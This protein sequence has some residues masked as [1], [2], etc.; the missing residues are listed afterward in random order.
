MSRTLG[1]LKDTFTSLMKSAQKMGLEIIQEKTLYMYSGKDGNKPNSISIGEYKFQR[2]DRFK[3]VGSMIDEENRR[4][5]EI[6]SV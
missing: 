1:G 3:Y 4:T 2:V 5:A 6:K